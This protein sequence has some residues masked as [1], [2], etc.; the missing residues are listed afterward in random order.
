MRAQIAG[1]HDRANPVS[2][3]QT[4]WR[5]LLAGWTHN[6]S[7][8]GSSPTRPTLQ[9]RKLAPGRVIV[10]GGGAGPADA[11]RNSWPLLALVTQEADV[12]RLLQAMG[13]GRGRNPAGKHV[14]YRDGDLELAGASGRS[15]RH[16]RR[17]YPGSGIHCVADVRQMQTPAARVG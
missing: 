9:N 10:G 15:A 16:L 7:V 13:S 11:F 12:W 2:P 3:G 17:P 6:P 4:I 8:V 5:G 1:N 14:P